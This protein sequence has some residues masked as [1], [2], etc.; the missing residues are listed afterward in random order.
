MIKAGDGLAHNQWNN[1]NGGIISSSSLLKNKYLPINYRQ[2]LEI[3]LKRVGH[4]R[5]DEIAC[6][7]RFQFKSYKF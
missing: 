7:P 2:V 5:R 6:T 4:N 3:S 1:R